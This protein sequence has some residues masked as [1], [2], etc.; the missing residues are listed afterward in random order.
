MRK[1]FTL[2]A[3]ALLTTGV[4]AQSPQKMSYQAVIR[5]VGGTLVQSHAIGMRISILQATSTGNAVYV[6]TQMPTTNGL[7]TIEIGSGTPVT[8][9]FADI[10]WPAGPYFVKTEIDPAGGTSYSITGTGQLLSVPYALYAKTAGGH[11]LGELYGGGIVVSVWKNAA[12]VEHGLIASLV[13]MSGGLVA[14]SN[15]T[16]LSVGTTNPIDGQGNTT[17]ITNQTGHTTSAAKLCVDYRGGGFSDW[18]LPAIWELKECYNATYAVNT[19][20][21]TTNGFQL[22]RYWSSKEDGA[23]TA[24]YYGFN[25]NVI[26]ASGI[27]SDPYKVRAVRKF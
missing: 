11:Y 20:L 9:T 27:K 2:L 19:V 3:A 14:W 24:Y 15:I 13:D 26:G 22:N 10:N 1:S 17:A 21:G 23:T 5:D 12:G 25:N 7:I 4:W 6:E 18:Y 16:D 8:G